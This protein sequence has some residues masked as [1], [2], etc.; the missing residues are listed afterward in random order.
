[1]NSRF[2]QRSSSLTFLG[3]LCTTLTVQAAGPTA[4]PATVSK[5]SDLT[6]VILK[7]E[8]EQR[9]RLKLVPVERRIIPEARLFSGEVV[10]PLGAEGG[11]AA[12]VVG[13]T[14]DEVLRLGELQVAAEGRVLQ[15]QVQVDA[16]QLAYERAKKMRQVEAG[17]LRT[18]DEAKT[19][20]ALAEA[21]LT[22]TKAQRELLGAVLGQTGGVRR[23]WVRVAIYTGEAALLDPKA[24]ANLRAQTATTTGQSVKPVAGPL[25]A[26]ALANTV[27]WYY[28]LPP[29]TS[30]RAGQR[31]AVEIPTLDSKNEH[32]LVPFNSV[33]YDIH[34]GQ[35]VYERI[36]ANT[37]TRRRVQVARLAGTEAVLTSGP[38]V[39]RQ[40]VT[41]GAAELFGTEFM[42]GK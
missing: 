7:P 24:M 34:G 15:A 22:T 23:V 37:Y 31:V 28:E 2:L 9:L 41:D 13:G 29:E 20:L 35:W 19:T 36:A 26:N 3:V 12:P 21:A 5:E 30:L 16:A 27:D 33:L 10:L 38:A 42:T 17:S 1:M 14:L 6:T 32:L 18:E 39:G 8:A 25:T 11:R 4:A 40:V